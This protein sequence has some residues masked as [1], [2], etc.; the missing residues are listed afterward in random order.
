MDKTMFEQTKLLIL[1]LD[2]TIADTLGALN[3]AVNATMR[4]YHWP[5]RTYEDVRL[6]IGNGA[7]KLIERSMPAPFSSDPDLVSAVL[8][9]YDKQYGLTY[10]H[11]D[12]CYPGMKESLMELAGRGYTFAVLSNKQDLYTKKLIA[13]LLGDLPALVM[14]QT[15]LPK[16]PDPTVPLLIAE[17]LGFSSQ[18]SAMVGDSDVDILTGQN[19]GMLTV[20]CA[21]GF[22]GR[23]CL[24]SV[25]ADIIADHPSDLLG[26]FGGVRP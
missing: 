18:E 8:K 4:K 25:H 26:L 14:G 24:E 10:M 19:A 22:R 12:T 17:K 5:E 15:D 2:G 21:W 20:G 16:K 6:A 23:A 1:D 13:Q 3:E 7:R 9:E 11:T